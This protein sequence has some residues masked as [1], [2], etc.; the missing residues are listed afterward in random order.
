[1]LRASARI[2]PSRLRI[3]ASLRA[4]DGPLPDGPSVR[5]LAGG[6]ATI[7]REAI[8][9]V[10]WTIALGRLWTAGDA[11]MCFLGDESLVGGG[12]WLGWWQLEC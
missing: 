7:E 9:E 5:D 10:A 4:E 3:W 11:L 2:S 8:D 1:M 12:W 6:D